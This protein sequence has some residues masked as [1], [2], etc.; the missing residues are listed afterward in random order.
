MLTKYRRAAQLLW[1]D[2]HTLGGVLHIPWATADP[3][4]AGTGG[5]DTYL[6]QAHWLGKYAGWVLLLQLVQ[7]R[8]QQHG[9]RGQP[10][11]QG[12]LLHLHLGA[13][14]PGLSAR[15]DAPPEEP[16]PTSRVQHHP[17]AGGGPH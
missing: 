16:P 11:L 5:E 13:S 7:H 15:G 6:L 17:G 4:E 10:Q 14:A 3:R 9:E 2:T 12:H 8:A 1:P